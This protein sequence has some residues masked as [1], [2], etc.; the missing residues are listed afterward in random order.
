MLVAIF[1]KLKQSNLLAQIPGIL[2]AFNGNLKTNVNFAQTAALAVFMKDVDINQIKM[3]AMGGHYDNLFNWNFVFTDQKKRVDLIKK[4]YGVDV[5]QESKYTHDAAEKKWA[6]MYKPIFT[7]KAQGLLTSAKSKLDA[8]AALPE[9]I[10]PTDGTPVPSTTPSGFKQYGADIWALYDKAQSEYAIL[11]LESSD[12]NSKPLE[13][14]EALK[15]IDQ[16]KKDIASLC[17][18]VGVPIKESYWDYKWET[19]KTINEITVNFN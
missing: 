11:A 2:D 13:G 6:E 1:D 5:K 15:A 7:G 12:E 18:K 16:L 19:D 4:I 14:E 3:Y 9:Y 8:D 17:K 10:A